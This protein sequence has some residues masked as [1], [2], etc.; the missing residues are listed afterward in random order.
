MAR[1]AARPRRRAIC[2][3]TC[4]ASTSNPL[5]TCRPSGADRLS[6]RIPAPLFDVQAAAGGGTVPPDGDL[7]RDADAGMLPQSLDFPPELLR[8]ITSAPAASLQMISVSG[9]SMTP[10]LADGDLVMIDTARKLPSPPGIFILDD[11]V[12]LVAK[13]VDTVPNTARPCCACHPTIRPMPII[14]AALTRCMSSG[15]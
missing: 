15:G 9:G 10:T 11:G 14:S 6:G 4:L 5:P 12:G 3:P 8:R 13:R 7:G 1:P 2:W